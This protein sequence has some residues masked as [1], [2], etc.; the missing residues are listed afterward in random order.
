MENLTIYGDA[1]AL[2]PDLFILIGRRIID[3]TG[4]AEKEQI[5]ALARIET[6]KYGRDE[7]IVVLAAGR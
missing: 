7:P 6:E 4:L 3:M 5:L 1:G 2:L